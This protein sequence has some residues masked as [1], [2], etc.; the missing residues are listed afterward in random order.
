MKTF[1]RN[2]VFASLKLTGL[3]FILWGGWV[4]FEIFT[5]GL[6]VLGLNNTVVWGVLITN[7]VFWIG[8]AHAGTFISAILLITRQDWRY[9][10]S[11][12]AESTT[13][14]ALL[15]A[16]MMPVIHLGVPEKF[17]EL[18]PNPNFKLNYFLVNFGS[19][20][21]WD[22]Y[23]IGTYFILSLLFIFMEWL[24]VL[25]RASLDNRMINKLFHRM[26]RRGLRWPL[27][28]RELAIDRMALLMT[29]LVISVHTVVS[30]DFAV[31]VKSNWHESVFPPYFVLGAVY[32]GF[33]LVYVVLIAAEYAGWKKLTEAQIR[34]ITGLLLFCAVAIGFLRLWMMISKA[35]FPFQ[36]S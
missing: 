3:L 13:V 17:Y 16:C 9:G 31:S 21:T 32:S 34:G 25:N 5:R 2:K 23:A 35:Y 19:P 33:A 36:Y 4:V 18:L 11:R 6:G 8:L 28:I 26:V 1:T 24:E 15:I 30:F 27:T 10:I 20:L 29:V 14:L 22:F 12:M 7:F